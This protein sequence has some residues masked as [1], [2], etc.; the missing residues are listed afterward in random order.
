MERC[1]VLFGSS[2]LWL[3]ELSQCPI[4]VCRVVDVAP[5]GVNLGCT[6][7]GMS[8]FLMKYDP[9]Q[10]R[11]P[12][13]STRSPWVTEH[14]YICILNSRD[15][16][17]I[18][19]CYGKE[20]IFQGNKILFRQNIKQII[21]GNEFKRNNN[22]G[23]R[24]VSLIERYIL[25]AKRDIILREWSSILRCKILFEVS[26]YFQATKCNFDWIMQFFEA[27]KYH[28]EGTKYY[29][30]QRNIILRKR[31]NIYTTRELNIIST[32]WNLIPWEWNS[33]LK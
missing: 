22:F 14:F 28:R 7:Q 18:W 10:N 26:K 20:I 32:E 25:L 5:P 15:S 27:M 19:Y 24:N 33:I 3:Q 23:K 16:S 1:A 17:I 21:L 6:L 30:G 9:F 2:C 29:L 11:L 13:V 12:A 4:D 8:R 31:N